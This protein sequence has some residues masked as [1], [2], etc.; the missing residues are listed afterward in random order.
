M[1]SKL[2]WFWLLFLLHCGY[3][4][5]QEK[6]EIIQ[7]RI[8]FLSEQNEAEELDLTNVFEQLD[9]YFEHPLNLNTAD[10]ETL[11]SLQLLSDIQ[12]N[13]L[14][15]HIKQFGKLIS[16]YELQSLAYWDLT[17]IEQVLP[18]VRVDDKLDQLH[19]TFHEAIKNGR[20]DWIL[21]YQRTPEFKQGYTKVPDSILATSNNYYHGN[22]DHYY[23]RFR[24]SYRTNL[25]AGI[26]ADKDP[27]EAF[28]KGSQPKG[29]DFY[30]AHLYYK[31]GKY[32]QAV[33]LGDYLV[34]I[35]Q[36]LNTWSGYAFGKT[37][38]IFSS[39]RTANLLRPYTSVDE[40]RYFR[41]GAAVFAYKKVSLLIFVSHKRIDGTTTNDSIVNTLDQVSAIDFSGLHRTNAEI[42]KKNR[43]SERVAGSYLTYHSRAFSVGL[44]VVNQQYSAVITKDSV[45][46]NNFV[47]RGTETT[48]I[49]SD[50]NF[51]YKNA[52]FFGEVAYAGHSKQV[53]QLH[54][55]LAVLDPRVSVAVIYR[56]YEPGYHSF[57][58]NGFSE[59]TA[60]QNE[61]GLFLGA[62]VKIASAWTLNM[63]ADYFRFPWLK[64]QV[65][66][67]SKGYEFLFQPVFRPSKI[68]EVYGRF[69]MQVRQKN[70]RDSDGT[71]TPLE[72]VVQRNYRLNMNYQV[73]E[74][75]QLKSRV[76]FVT[77]NRPSN[78]PESG[79]IMTQDIVLH[80]K[81]KPFDLSLRYAL[82]ETD[83]Y[84]ARIYTFENNA[85]GVFSVPAYYYQ[86]SR[87][88]F[89]FRYSF[90]KHWDFWIKY[91]TS[92]FSDRTTIGSGAEEINGNRK[93]DITLQLRLSL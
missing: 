89:L 73:T 78:T 41:G 7:Q 12:I 72:N 47:F 50:Y 27:G 17:I 48:T 8:E 88:Y 24:Y 68:L 16:I 57:Y 56:N 55:M 15:L 70:S 93:S 53:A 1:K 30:S 31:G 25:S 26:T 83:S 65:D 38:D 69:R 42:A 36:G 63:Y 28:F 23:A 2:I 43:F 18:F 77:I 34:Q 40:N 4:F 85:I 90:L 39:K 71:I 11:K 35:G 21:R 20:F 10:F 82:F 22:P 75:V 3:S 44:A 84:D 87:A 67:P 58:N 64:F 19:I 32:I 13:N 52:N 79:W 37:A 60:T 62:K 6:N 76:E 51:T 74:A 92:I 59:G 80:P 49:S 14:L 29:F 86:G 33:A 66:A 91:G 9:Y 46:Y 54:G 61:K 45:P 5:S 81:S